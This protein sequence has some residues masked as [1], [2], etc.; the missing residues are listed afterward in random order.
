MI[1]AVDGPSGA[2]KSS[3]CRAVAQRL[4]LRLLDTG[5]IYRCV[6][7]HAM[8]RALPLEDGPRLAQAAA[9]LEI[10]F[11]PGD[12]VQRVFLDGED[13]SAAIRTL[14]V[15]QAVNK[16]SALPEVRAALLDLQ[17]RLGQEV[18]C[19]VEGRDIGTVVFPD[20]ALKVFFTASV[21]ARA[22]RRQVELAGRGEAHAL[23]AMMAHIAERDATETQRAA[24]PL[25]VAPGAVVL[26]TSAMDFAGACDALAALIVAAR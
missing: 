4:G 14:A 6:A 21:E 3:V 7:L 10:A 22:R 9:G 5:A 25:V 17:R 19:I 11:A 8:R 23:E 12:D 16:V 2:G 13:V 20:A 18:D 15:T 26:D 24:A 1:V